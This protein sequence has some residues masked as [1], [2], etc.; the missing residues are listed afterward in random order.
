MFDPALFRV[1]P[2]HDTPGFGVLL[3]H[4]R[5]REVLLLSDADAEGAR[6]SYF[7]SE[8]RK[9]VPM[10]ITDGSSWRGLFC[11]DIRVRVDHTATY[12]PQQEWAARGSLIVK[13]GT[14]WLATKSANPGHFEDTRPYPLRRQGETGDG[15]V[16]YL[17][18]VV[19]L[20]HGDDWIIVHRA[21]INAA[22]GPS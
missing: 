7:L 15:A 11:G 21:E 20:G 17:K 10:A 14:L 18:W 9:Y 16:G 2:I 3:P 13:E 22:S 8:D 5:Q 1:L 6:W 19:E 12:D 4:G